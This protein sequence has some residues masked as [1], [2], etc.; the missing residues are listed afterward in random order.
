[1]HKVGI[2]EAVVYKKPYTLKVEEVSDPK[3]THPT[4]ALLK[5]TST[6]ICG[7]DLHMYEGRSSIESGTVLG[8]EIMGVI[9]EVGECV[10]NIQKGDRVVLPFNIACGFC[11]NC[12]LG[13]TNACLT[14][15]PVKPT[16]GY[17]YANMGP[18]R[19]GQAERVLV[20]FADYNCLKLPGTPHD[21]FENDFVLLADI[22][23]T[24]YHAT[25]LAMMK[26]GYP[27]AIFG[28]GPVG[29][30]AALSASIRGASEIYVVDWVPD[31]LE[32]AK[33]IGAIPIDFT[34]GSPVEQIIAHREENKLIQESLRPG[35]AKINGILSAIDAIGYEALSDTDISKQNPMQVQENIIELLDYTGHIGIIGVFFPMDPGG[36]DKAARMGKYLYPLGEVFEKGLTIGTG[37]TPV[38]KYN[39][40]LRDLIIAGK[41]K[42]SFIVSKEITISEAP[43][44]YEHFDKREKGYSKVIIKFK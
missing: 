2:Y 43:D 23:P 34:K 26:T 17:G 20:P 36:V 31:R 3:I 33:S 4:D 25:E 15:N 9:E 24:G 6:A 35:E 18:Y 29:L 8:H 7:S 19:G 11:K 44:A 14:A 32:K 1:M 39:M 21:E 5:V 16:A 30:L 12:V 38:K 13:F 22:F 42:P 27:I 37:Q 40:F 28:A 41:A 10:Q